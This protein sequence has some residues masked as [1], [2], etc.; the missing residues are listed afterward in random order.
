MF[1][2]SFFFLDP[3]R[4]GFLSGSIFFYAIFFLICFFLQIAWGKRI[5]SPRP[6]IKNGRPGTIPICRNSKSG[7]GFGCSNRPANRQ[8]QTD[9]TH[10]T[11][12][13]TNQPTMLSVFF[14]SLDVS[15]PEF[16]ILNLAQ[17]SRFRT[18][19]LRKMAQN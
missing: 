11:N 10:P 7:V 6:P 4:V 16:R 2:V 5:F 15:S 12:Q 17:R 1:G 19:K 8:R 3:I 14:S 18:K 13:P 9:Q